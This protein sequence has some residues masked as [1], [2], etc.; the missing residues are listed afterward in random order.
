M[1]NN[2]DKLSK[3]LYRY[4]NATKI[5]NKNNQ[6]K[7]EKTDDMDNNFKEQLKQHFR[8]LSLNNKNNRSEIC[9]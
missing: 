2:N 8:E 3:F 5:T 9:S 7:K 1:N 6:S 4:M